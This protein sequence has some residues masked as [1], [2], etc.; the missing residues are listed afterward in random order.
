VV[1]GDGQVAGEEQQVVVR[2]RDLG[3]VDLVPVGV[4]VA[5]DAETEGVAPGL[6]QFHGRSARMEQRTAT[7]MYFIAPVNARNRAANWG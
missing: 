2:A 1:D 6:D 5:D 3:E 7:L 4:Q